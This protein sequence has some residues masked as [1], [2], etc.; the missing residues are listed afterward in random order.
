MNYQIITDEKEL[1]RVCHQARQADVVML[2][3][4]FV[5]TRTYY[6][7]LGLIQL[8]DGENLSLI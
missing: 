4:E 1:N 7:Q 2:D 5:R 3:T 6:P 8:F